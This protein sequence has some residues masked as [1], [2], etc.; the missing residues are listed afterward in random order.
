MLVNTRIGACLLSV[1]MVFAL[2]ALA[3]CTTRPGDQLASAIKDL[4]AAK[5]DHTL[6]RDGG[7]LDPPEV[8]VWFVQGATKDEAIAAWCQQIQALQERIAPDVLVSLWLATEEFV[9]AP[10]TCPGDLSPAP[11]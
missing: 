7:S 11:S 3:A 8:Y 2:V 5:V 1:V 10:D 9:S 6:F 4:S